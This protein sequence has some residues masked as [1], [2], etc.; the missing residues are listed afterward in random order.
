MKNSIKNIR[1]LLFCKTLYYICKIWRPYL[2]L[3]IIAYLNL[4]TIDLSLGKQIKISVK[5][6]LIPNW[7][8][9]IYIDRNIVKR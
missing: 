9:R 2:F 1:F 4:K 8:E 3:F 7:S 5:E 6:I